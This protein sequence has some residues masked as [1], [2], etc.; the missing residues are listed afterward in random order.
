LAEEAQ[1]S[2]ATVNGIET[3]RTTPSLDTMR[4]ICEALGVDPLDIDEFRDIIMGKELA[5]TTA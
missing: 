2:T 1:V 4:K 3:G 5:P